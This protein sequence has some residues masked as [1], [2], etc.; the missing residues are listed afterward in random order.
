MEHFTGLAFN[1]IG[2]INK[3]ILFSPFLFHS[4]KLKNYSNPKVFMS[5]KSRLQLFYLIFNF[6]NIY[7]KKFNLI[8]QNTD[9]TMLSAYNLSKI[10]HGASSVLKIESLQSVTGKLKTSYHY[11]KGKSFDNRLVFSP[12]CAHYAVKV[13]RWAVD[14]NVF[15]CFKDGYFLGNY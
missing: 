11:V 2:W 1:N 14:N 8:M 7:F 6:L 3:Q 15:F 12:Q 4:L 13:V 9:P 10:G 5:Y